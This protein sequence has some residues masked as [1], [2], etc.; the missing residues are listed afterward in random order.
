ML[1]HYDSRPLFKWGSQCVFVY[2]YVMVGIVF[3]FPA[4]SSLVV[5]YYYSILLCFELLYLFV[6]G[7]WRMGADLLLVG[8]TDFQLNSFTPFVFISFHLSPIQRS[9][10]PATDFPIVTNHSYLLTLE[11]AEPAVC[12]AVLCWL[13]SDP[14]TTTRSR[15]LQMEPLHL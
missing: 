5:F 8:M 10:T 1:L 6:C 4:S 3:F 9:P 15:L 2:I 12:I 13:F 11:P 7:C 14:C